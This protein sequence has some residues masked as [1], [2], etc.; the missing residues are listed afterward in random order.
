MSKKR[1][2]FVTQ[3]MKPYT[4]LSEISEIVRRLPTYMHEQGMEIRILM[5]RF[6]TI[7]ERRHRLHEVV[8]LSGMNIIVDDDDYPLIIKVASLPGARLQV[9]FLDNDEF[10]RRKHLFTD[11]SGSPFE[12]NLDR[13][14]FFSK[15]VLETIKKFGWPPDIIHCHGWMTSLVPL[16]LKTAYKNEP[17]FAHTKVI[18]S[19][20]DPGL[21]P[22]N[23]SE[24]FRE[25][26]AINNLET[27]LLDAY[28]P[29][30]G[31]HLDSGAVN[32]AD[33]V[34]QGSETID[35]SVTTQLTDSEKPVL[36][37]SNEDA[38]LGEYLKFYK[39]LLS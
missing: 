30:N 9:Y 19:V 17:L 14:V 8:R 3:E 31:L 16:Y 39:Q 24:H 7:N 11:G 38:Y 12:D 33:A 35:Q 29:D 22:P 20:Y 32:Y 28:S 26:A 10:F 27:S 13:M 34:I 23:L 37:H 1:I 36:Q 18:Y 2:L 4:T 15:G 6:G 5:P 25:K 21:I